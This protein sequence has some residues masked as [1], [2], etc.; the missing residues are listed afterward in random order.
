MT[1]GDGKRG[2]LV[3]GLRD[4]VESGRQDTDPDRRLRRVAVLLEPELLLGDRDRVAARLQR[5]VGG[6]EG[7]TIERRTCSNSCRNAASS[8]L[9]CCIRAGT[10]RRFSS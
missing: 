2:S 6:L 3:R 1:C 7:L 5:S 8:F 9:T 4:T 10:A